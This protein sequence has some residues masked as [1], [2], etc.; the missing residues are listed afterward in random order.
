MKRSEIDFKG[1]K[2]LLIGAKKSGIAAVELLEERGAECILSDSNDKLKEEE[3]KAQFSRDTKCRFCFGELSEDIKREAELV[4]ISPGV[5]VDLPLLDQLRERG[6]KIWGEV[7]L[8]YR[9]SKGDLLAITGTNG[10]TTTTALLGK[11]CGDYFDSSFVVGNIGIPYTMEAA[12]MQEDSVTVAEISSFQLETI[13]EFHPSVSAILNI[14]PDHLNRHHTMECYI[15]MKERIAENQTMEDTVVLNY[16]DELTRD[17]GRRAG[18]RVLY[19][20]RLKE[21]TEYEESIYL[22]EDKKTIVYKKGQEIIRVL[23]VDELKLLG[24]HNVENVLA[25]LGMALAYGV[26]SQAAAE[27][28]K[29]FTAVEHRIEF[30]RTAEGVDYYNDSKGTNVDAA[31]KGIKAMNK[32]TVLIGGGYDKMSEYDEWIEAF[33]GKVKGLVLLGQ[34][35]EKIAACARRHGFNDIY[36]AKDMAEAVA[37][38]H[39]I[40]QSGDAVLLSP[41]C[42]SWG[43]FDNYEQRGHI[44]KELVNA[45]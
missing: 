14:T 25:A 18:C 30:V 40:A 5:P 44:F 2:V 26:P 12:K 3:V 20:S 42:A 35:A 36:F 16:D 45:L 28:A 9:L 1:K 17:F 8:A 34:T 11:I 32:R 7:E 29:A 41:A 15:A 22:L 39:E 10:K 38:C 31:I 37:K 4:V 43:M 23:S 19:F 13:E 27:S 33:E 6:V 21:L 24:D